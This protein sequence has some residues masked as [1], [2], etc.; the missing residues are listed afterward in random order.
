MKIKWKCIDNTYGEYTT[1][2]NLPYLGK[3]HIDIL[4]WGNGGN[5][6]YALEI[7]PQNYLRDCIDVKWFKTLTPK[8]AEKELN[9]ILNQFLR[10]L[11]GHVK[12]LEKVCT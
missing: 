8:Q 3:T 4:Y 12:E 9:K 11:K 10:Q 2:V 1:D 5:F 6:E 7:T